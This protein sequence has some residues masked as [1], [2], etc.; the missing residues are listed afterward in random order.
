[1]GLQSSPAESKA[2]PQHRRMSLPVDVGSCPRPEIGLQEAVGSFSVFSLCIS[3][4]SD[5]VWLHVMCDQMALLLVVSPCGVSMRGNAS[6]C[7]CSRGCLT[8]HFGLSS[9]S[10]HPVT[11]I[12]LNS[13]TFGIPLRTSPPSFRHL[14]SSASS[15]QYIVARLL[16]PAGRRPHCQS[17]PA[18]NISQTMSLI[19]PIWPHLILSTMKPISHLTY[20]LRMAGIRRCLPPTA[21]RPSW[22]TGPTPKVTDLALPAPLVVLS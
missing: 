3:P 22:A 12:V 18:R 9:T 20:R 7:C 5:V 2:A 8:W 10:H 4:K 1:M 6:L 13:V 11:T 17:W 16:Q 15:R 14:D 19:K 21:Y